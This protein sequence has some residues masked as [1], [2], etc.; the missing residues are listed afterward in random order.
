MVKCIRLLAG[1]AAFLL[2]AAVGGLGRV[3]SAELLYVANTDG[4]NVIRFTPL[5][6]GTVFSASRLKRPLGMA[7]N[8]AGDLMVSN[9]G[10]HTISLL[11]VT[12]QGS[13]LGFSGLAEPRGIAVDSAGNTYVANYDLGENFAY[14]QKFAPDGASSQFAQVAP[15]PW[16]I[17]FDK[18]ENLYVAS[19]QQSIIQKITP[20]GAIS[21]F[22]STDMANPFGV[23]FDADGNLFAANF[24]SHS[25][26]R[27][28][29]DG[30][31][32]KFSETDFEPA[33]LAFDSAGFLY[34]SALG[35]GTIEKIA[36]DGTRS[37]FAS[38]LD[39]PTMMTFGPDYMY[40]DAVAAVPEPASLAI[41]GLGAAGLLG[42]RRERR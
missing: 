4:S 35:T 36:T 14:I 26:T 8:A 27:I 3:A 24:G 5:G 42:R 29:P 32:S 20:A 13:T 6:T 15:S 39:N 40:F 23:A 2:I 16:G 1:G 38:G 25:I 21:T 10:N 12:G 7:F 19:G 41:L 31:T 18:D 22:A 30:T 33:G 28:A 34:V 9:N 37:V 11:T 17:A